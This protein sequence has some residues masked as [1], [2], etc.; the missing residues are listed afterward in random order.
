MR[1]LRVPFPANLPIGLTGLRRGS[2]RAEWPLAGARTDLIHETSLEV[3]VR[4][5]YGGRLGT[6]LGK[7]TLAVISR[8]RGTDSQKQLN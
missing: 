6:P 8:I 3:A 1:D 7:I 4:R 2:R 5:A